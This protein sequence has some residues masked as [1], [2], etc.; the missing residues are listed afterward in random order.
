MCAKARSNYDIEQRKCSD[1]R[2]KE[3]RAW[4]DK[5]NKEKERIHFDK[6]GHEDKKKFEKKKDG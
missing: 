5:V 4:E 3:D 6:M 2:D 1:K